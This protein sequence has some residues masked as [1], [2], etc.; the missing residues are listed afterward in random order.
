MKNLLIFFLLFSTSLFAATYNSDGSQADV[1]SK[2]N[3]ASSGDTVTIPSGSFTW[4]SGV[5]ISGKGIK[6]QGA[7]G[8]R[9]EGS[10]NTALSLTTGSKSFTIRSGSTINGFTVAETLIVHDKFYPAN[11][12][13]GTVTNW[14][15]T[16]LG[17]NIT[18]A[19]GS[20]PSNDWDFE[21]AAAT[22]LILGQ[23]AYT[24]LF[25]IS[26]DA[27]TSTEITG[28][29]FYNNGS[30]PNGYGISFSGAGKDPLIHDL[31]FSSVA[32]GIRGYVNGAV[33]W[34]CYFEAGWNIAAN[35]SAVNN[36]IIISNP[37]ATNDWTDAN[38]VGTNDAG[39]VRNI[40]IEQCYWLGHVGGG[41]DFGDN[42]RGVIRY[43][44][45]D[46]SAITYHGV[47]TGD[48]S[49]R[50]TEIYNNIFIFD[51]PSV[52]F[53]AALDH[54]VHWRGGSGIMTDN[55]VDNIN[56]TAYGNKPEVDLVYQALGRTNTSQFGVYG[57]PGGTDGTLVHYPAAHQPGQGSN[58]AA[59]WFT[60][61]GTPKLYTATNT[62]T[63]GCYFYNN[64]GTVIVSVQ[65][66][67]NEIP[68]ISPVRNAAN[69]IQLNRDY[70]MTAPQAGTPFYGYQKFTYPHPLR[71]TQPPSGAKVT[72]LLP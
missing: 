27:T 23:A 54:W 60:S 58:G 52:G 13:T 61:A 66:Y 21:S 16:T 35:P 30:S 19:T 8:G 17:M 12:M 42:C 34:K 31:R 46:D 15:G 24:A 18:A 2:I 20:S 48:Y 55:V 68:G 7:G 56:S 40:Y 53:P 14:D 49:A 71:P 44:V 59:A 26:K 63:E 51:V 6:I 69:Y 29:R 62:Y 11:T 10:S 3:S 47:D 5:T 25:V 50:H 33:I 37:S 70:F 28:F 38:T 32:Q 67:A 72:I 4:T 43:C 39:G 1:Q 9:V 57:W 22:N 65:T 64:T 41:I 45:F 36:G